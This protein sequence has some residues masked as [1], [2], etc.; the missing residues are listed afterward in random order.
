MKPTLPAL[1]SLL[2][3]LSSA[4]DD[5][6]VGL[7]NAC[8]TPPPFP[9]GRW[10]FTEDAGTVGISGKSTFSYVFEGST[11]T[12]S[13]KASGSFAYSR[14]GGPENN[15]IEIDCDGVVTGKGKDRFAGTSGAAVE[16]PPC[17][18]DFVSSQAI[19]TIN[20]EYDITG[21]A[22]EDGSLL[23]TNTMTG[24][25][26]TAS[27]KNVFTTG[28]D[29]NCFAAEDPADYS[30]NLVEDPM[31]VDRE[32]LRLNGMFNTESNTWTSV[33][34]T[35]QLSFQ[36][37]DGIAY[38]SAYGS[39]L[40]G[41]LRDHGCAG[42]ALG[43]A[44]KYWNY[45]V[46]DQSNDGGTNTITTTLS[47]KLTLRT[48]TVKEA[49]L[50]EP[51]FFIKDIPYTTT[52]FLTPDW[53]ESE[54]TR[55]VE[56]VYD[57][58]TTTLSGDTVMFQFDTDKADDKI[59]I[60]PKADEVGSQ[61]TYHV[62]KVDLPP[63]AGKISDW[64]ASSGVKY[65]GWVD[66]PISLETTR[67][68]SSNPLFSGQWGLTAKVSSRLD[69][70]ANSTGVP[71]TADFLAKATA[72]FAGRTKELELKGRTTT[73]LEC[74]ALTMTGFGEAELPLVD[75]EASLNPISL[76][77][78]A[79][80]AACAL[81]RLPCSLTGKAGL[82]ASIKINLIGRPE[83]GDDGSEIK[84]TGGSLGGNMHAS[85]SLS[86]VPPPLNKVANVTV[87]GGGEGCI[88]FQ[89]AP[90]LKLNTLG[91]KV[92]ASVTASALFLGSATAYAE[93][94]FGDPCGGGAPA[95][96]PS[97]RD[98]RQTFNGSR[99]SLMGLEAGNTVDRDVNLT[100]ALG[101][102]NRA[103]AAWSQIPQGQQRPSGD[104]AIKLFDGTNWGSGF[105]I[106]S[107]AQADNG[108]AV[109]YDGAGNIL[110]CYQRNSTLPLPTDISQ[111]ATFAAGFEL[112]YAVLDPTNGTVIATAALTGNSDFD[113]GPLLRTDTNGF[114]HLFWQRTDGQSIEGVPGHEAS[115][116]HRVWNGAAWSTEEALVSGLVDSLGWHPAVLDS[117][118]CFV[119]V[120]LDHD[121]NLETEN[122]LEIHVV[123]KA[124][125]VVRPIV[126][127]T[128]NSLPDNSPV[129]GFDSAGR[130]VLVWREDH[131][132]KGLI[133]SLQSN[134][135]TLVAAPLE[136][137]P[138]FANGLL[139]SVGDELWLVWP[140]ANDI[141]FTAFRD[142][143]WQ[144]PTAVSFTDDADELFDARVDESTGLRL[145][146]ASTAF[147]PGFESLAASSTLNVQSQTTGD[148]RGEIVS[149]IYD[150][151]VTRLSV[152]GEGQTEYVLQGN[153]DLGNSDGWTDLDTFTTQ[154]DGRALIRHYPPNGAT[155]FYYLL[156]RME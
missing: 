49:Y 80:D 153:P 75:W 83:F 32:V 53:K 149:A 8:T 18:A 124:A 88:E 150:G 139:R 78:G 57:G 79:K 146:T 4:A 65:E 96:V 73:T 16:N 68:I 133:G 19:L 58:E 110:L 77:L 114:V 42:E 17:P 134:V 111:F 35:P 103:V 10:E 106:T 115:I 151:S 67:S 126:Q 30:G 38:E 61:F 25:A 28:S 144:K 41:W 130:P 3:A 101:S 112:H 33:T 131:Q 50:Q 89:V 100:M 118:N 141:H 81:G 93:W 148:L 37:E 121:G 21:L 36:E 123:Q 12:Y 34:I 54:G 5:C 142:G 113:F 92:Y 116:L 20:R 94:P 129:A 15:F 2:L 7:T 74:D 156:K 87:E 76:V 140:G 48:P 6:P 147:A 43:D 132:L 1:G 143:V 109:A 29:G 27:M 47:G 105:L 95:Q 138:T 69:M 120:V 102:G 45:M 60:T 59:L 85:V 117:A 51:Q 63:W 39:W 71:G 26:Y 52:L 72:S 22:Q 135:T 84:W 13:A 119:A 104:I 91:G 82:S 90:D 99:R 46:D 23:L 122:D 11:F 70:K 97:R 145:A 55:E 98:I 40:A 108:P 14:V 31:F 155:E 128:T 62:P 9:T 152:R 66:W 107:D 154:T 127:V 136:V 125:G 86:V 24:G 56:F 44:S 64:H 137:G